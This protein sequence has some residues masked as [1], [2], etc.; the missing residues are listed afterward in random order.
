M[1]VFFTSLLVL[2]SIVCGAQEIQQLTVQEFNALDPSVK[3]G[4]TIISPTNH[5]KNYFADELDGFVVQFSQFDVANAPDSRELA[6]DSL[7]LVVD[8]ISMLIHSLDPIIITGLEEG[9]H[10]IKFTSKGNIPFQGDDEMGIVLGDTRPLFENDAIVFGLLLAILALIFWTSKLK[11]FSKFYSI[12]P[13]LLLCYFIPAIFNSFDIV[14]SNVSELYTMAKNYLLPAALVLLCLSIDLKGIFKLGPKALIMFFTATIGI[15]L[16]GPVALWL[17]SMWFPESMVAPEGEEV[18]RGLSTVAGSWIGGGANQT[19]MKEI[20][21]VG[22]VIFSQMIIVDV[23][24]ANVFMSLI[25][26]GIGKRKKIDRWLKADN[27]AIDKLQEKMHNYSLSVSRIPSFK[28]VM[29]M[30]GVVF[31]VIG[32]SH[33]FADLL[34]PYFKGIVGKNPYLSFLK[35]G[36]FWIVVLATLFG[37]LLSFT[38]ARKMEG[39]GASR[40]GSLFIYILVATI[41]MKMDIEQLI[42]NWE[43]F[44]VLIII[45]LIW[46]AIHGLLLL[47]VAKLIKAPYFFAA[48]GSQA[49]V[50]GA[51]S[52]PVVAGAFHPSLAPVGVL[53]AV[54]GYAVGTI[55]AIICAN[56]LMAVSP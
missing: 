32:L 42:A 36:F 43:T 22:D 18:W 30:I 49:N 8:S 56:M 9:E 35:S 7:T 44:K 55:A 2:I 29:V 27:S 26:F 50:G 37:V 28:D 21:D 41:G 19:A 40:V 24:I 1:K 23:F 12:I 39:V 15:M 10:T 14:N 3:E 34:G 51:A 48:V 54:L 20:K 4:L 11:G 16:G 25:L 53:L 38:K 13:A 17:C 52:A 31:A 33:V 45:G 6:K 47:I 5:T 46:I